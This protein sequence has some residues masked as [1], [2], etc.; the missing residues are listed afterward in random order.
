MI[1]SK[2]KQK[3]WGNNM[4]MQNELLSLIE[5]QTDTINKYI[6]SMTFDNIDKII[7]NKKLIEQN[8]TLDKFDFL[9]QFNLEELKLILPKS[10]ENNLNN[11]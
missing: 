10:F 5:N 7:K 11:L 9:N 4:T 2:E 8:S 1:T 6:S 3:D